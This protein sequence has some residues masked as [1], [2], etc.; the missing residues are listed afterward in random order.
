MRQ[1][2]NLQLDLE[3]VPKGRPRMGRGG[4][5]YTPQRTRDCEDLLKEGVVAEMKK[6][7]QRMVYGPVEVHLKLFSSRKPDLDNQIKT[8]LD[9][10]QGAIIEDD[11]QVRAIYAERV[12]GFPTVVEV[13][14]LDV[15][16]AEDEAPVEQ[17]PAT[18]PVSVVRRRTNE[19]GKRKRRRR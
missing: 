4:R 8:A 10:I 9:G 7:K 11:R 15:H 3:I 16:G 5:F 1:V 18:S 14:E 13:F 17:E 12:A 19:V 6:T 2:L